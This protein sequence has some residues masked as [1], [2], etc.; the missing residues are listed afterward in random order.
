VLRQGQK[1]NPFDNA[2]GENFIKTL[3][4]E[5]VHLWE[6]RKMEDVQRRI[7]YLLE[8][9]FNHKWLYSAIGCCPPNEFELLWVEV[10]GIV[11]IS[12]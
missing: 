7:P 8:D 4:S 11:A 10:D 5:E 3:K 1:G 12:F 9:F 2:Y 6:F